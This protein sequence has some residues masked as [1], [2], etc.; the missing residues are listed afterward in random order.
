MKFFLSFL[1]LTLSVSAITFDEWLTETSNAAYAQVHFLEPSIENNNLR[2]SLIKS[3]E[4]AGPFS[5]P[6][7]SMKQ[8]FSKGVKTATQQAHFV[9]NKKLRFTY[10]VFRY[11]IP[12]KGGKALLVIKSQ[13]N[14]IAYLNGKPLNQLDG[15]LAVS[16][17]TASPYITLRQGENKLI[18]MSKKEKANM[19]PI[20]FIPVSN[21]DLKRVRAELQKF[22]T[23]NDSNIE[24][25]MKL[26]KAMDKSSNPKIK[27]Y[28]FQQIIK[29]I[30]F[31]NN[32]D[33]SHTIYHDLKADI[34]YEMYKQLKPQ[35]LAAALMQGHIKSFK[36]KLL[37]L[38]QNDEGAYLEK[39]FAA[40]EKTTTDKNG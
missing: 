26:H 17:R 20:T 6:V 37:Y 39:L 38:I 1:C 12:S 24:D 33:C 16:R 28:G 3:I 25:F 32:R 29:N 31:K 14:F 36:K 7:K 11:K 13:D 15:G 9:N 22:K 30:D 8:V 19:A 34:I 21:G 23:I 5:Q 10:P 35:Q 27:A 18:L 2:K 4:V 40:S